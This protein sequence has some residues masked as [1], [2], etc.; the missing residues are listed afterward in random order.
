MCS[1]M[2]IF[3][4]SLLGHISSINYHNCL[5]QT[6]SAIVYSHTAVVID[7]FGMTKYAFV[8]NTDLHEGIA[9]QMLK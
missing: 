5:P 4:F 6:L 7:M 9:Q 3:K 1:D 8:V 2:L